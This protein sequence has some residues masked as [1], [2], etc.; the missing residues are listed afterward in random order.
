[1]ILAGMILT[2]LAM[3]FISYKNWMQRIAQVRNT[4]MEFEED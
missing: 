2:M 1:M 3:I 4:Q